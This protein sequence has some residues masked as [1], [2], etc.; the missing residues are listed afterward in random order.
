MLHH[1]CAIQREVL[2]QGQNYNFLIGE[3]A[4]VRRAL[5]A[6]ISD[7]MGLSCVNCKT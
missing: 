4:Y 1:N 3:L 7:F 5:V 2:K 6:Y